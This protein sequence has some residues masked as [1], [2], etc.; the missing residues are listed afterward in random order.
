MYIKVPDS[1][2]RLSL[3]NITENYAR[4]IKYHVTNEVSEYGYYGCNAMNTASRCIKISLI[5]NILL[6]LII[7]V[8]YGI[9]MC[10]SVAVIIPNNFTFCQPNHMIRLIILLTI[11][12]TSLQMVWWAYNNTIVKCIYLSALGKVLYNFY[13]KGDTKDNRDTLLSDYMIYIAKEWDYYDQT[14]KL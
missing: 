8:A 9:G 6:L 3:L 4:Y 2:I 12:S 7:P 1:S 14:G 11:V 13:I 5:Y 10:I